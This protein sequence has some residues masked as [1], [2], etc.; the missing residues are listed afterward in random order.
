MKLLEIRPQLLLRN[1]PF[2]NDLVC[3]YI[4]T[5]AHWI[6]IKFVQEPGTVD[7]GRS[8]LLLMYI[9]ADSEPGSRA[10]AVSEPSLRCNIRLGRT[11][12]WITIK[13]SELSGDRLLKPLTYTISRALGLYLEKIQDDLEGLH[14]A[15]VRVLQ[16][17]YYVLGWDAKELKVPRKHKAKQIRIELKEVYACRLHRIAWE[18]EQETKY[19]LLPTLPIKVALTPQEASGLD[20]AERLFAENPYLKPL[21][22]LDDHRLPFTYAKRSFHFDLLKRTLTEIDQS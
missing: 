11:N 9:H 8:K 21:P 20:S 14:L 19:L 4:A 18:E 6:G 2:V 10:D 12:D 15:T 7:F 16:S 22:W 17:D 3:N 13:E 1:Q 5:R